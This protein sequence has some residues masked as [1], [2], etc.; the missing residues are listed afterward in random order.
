MTRTADGP[1][2]ARLVRPAVAEMGG[3]KPGEQSNS[4]DVVKLNT[5]ENPY[6][7][8]PRVIEAIRAAA[9]DLRLYPDPSALSL[10]K[11]AGSVWGVDP[12]GVVVGNGSDELLTVLFRAILDAGDRVAYPVSTYSLYDTLAEL[13]GVE[14]LGVPYGPNWEFPRAALEKCD[15]RLFLICRPNAPSGTLPS[16]A[17]VRSLLASRPDAVVVVDE[18]YADFAAENAIGL[19]GSYPN[20]VVLRTLSKSYSLC[21]LRV[22]FA[23][24]TADLA[25]QLHKVRDSY[26]LSAV[27]QAGGEAALL[28]QEHFAIN[29]GKILQSRTRL[30]DE[31]RE[32]GYQVADSHTN[33]VL[34]TKPGVPQKQVFEDLRDKGVL[35]RWFPVLPDSIRVTVGTD[36]EI[37]RFFL[38]LG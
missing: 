38:A 33:F 16:I 12:H 36:T 28:D 13:Q 6:A 1:A 19:V 10:R 21:G 26:N 4:P 3:Y 30:V 37:D 25:A 35:V 22:G 9:S 14:A 2:A 7:A 31:L 27:A 11:A 20:L 15:A 34:A 18:A 32:R 17:D 24:T 23:L 5:N 29:R 8:S